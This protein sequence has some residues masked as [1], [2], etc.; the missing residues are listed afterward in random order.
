MSDSVVEISDLRKS[1]RVGFFQKSVE[2]LKG[3][4]FSIPKGTVTGFL[5]K[6]GAGKTTTIK[7]VLQLALHSSGTIRYF[8]QSQLTSEIKNKIGFLP[9][10]PYFYE[11]LTGQE[12]LRF[13]GEISTQL[14]RK[15]LNSR[16]DELLELVELQH[17]KNRPLRNYSKGMLQRVGIAQ[18]LIHKPEFV[19][20]DEPMSGLDPDGRYTVNNIIK[21]T[22]ARGTTVFFS[23]HLLHD[24]EQICQNL[25]VMKDG[26]VIYQGGMEAL[27][28]RLQTGY[29][30]SY[31][32]GQARSEEIV[33]SPEALQ[34]KIDDLRRNRIDILEVGSLKPSLEEAF[35][36]IS[37]TGAAI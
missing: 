32:S 17:A 23:S 2:V 26:L 3:V 14:D 7:C 16:I 25:V 5:G 12:F 6:N 20:F 37:H 9:E 31:A 27:L 1:Y 11:Y 30:I 8:G 29:R 18:A 36:K 13:Y 35:V 34:L 21:E 10:R 19:I 15:A 22:A 33:E 28:S 4:T 24:A